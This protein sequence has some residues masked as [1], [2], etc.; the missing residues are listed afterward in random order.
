MEIFLFLFILS[1]VA[2]YFASTKSRS[3]FG[4]FFLSLLISPIITLIILAII[5]SK[6]QINLSFDNKLKEL[7][8]MRRN[9]LL[10][11]EEYQ[12]K[13]KAVIDSL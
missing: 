9:G 3:G 2:G 12:T 4:W 7:E 5:P 8:R 11:E 6:S 13:R 10:S 1:I